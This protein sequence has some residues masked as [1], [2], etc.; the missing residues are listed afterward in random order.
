MNPEPYIYILGIRIDEPVTVV[1]DLVVAGICIL[2]FIEI[3]RNNSPAKSRSFY[4]L[5]FLLLGVGTTAGGLF[6]HAFLYRLHP[7]WQLPGWLISMAATSLIVMGSFETNRKS[8]HPWLAFTVIILNISIFLVFAIIVILSIDFIYVVIQIAFN[9]LVLLLT[10]QIIGWVKRRK[11]GHLLFTGAIGIMI[12]AALIFLMK[13]SINTWID[14]NGISHFL[15]AVSALFF[16][17]GIRRFL[18]D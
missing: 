13:L 18:S 1:T 16:F 6:G 9:L 17:F 8:L 15:M 5:F 14:H 12:V 10:L 4:A 2:A 7:A 11:A 3:L